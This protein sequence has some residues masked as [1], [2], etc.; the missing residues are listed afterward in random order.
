MRRKLQLIALAALASMVAVAAALSAP[1]TREASPRSTL[2]RPDDAR[3]PQIHVV[4][5]VPSD[6]ADHGLDTDGTLEATVHSWNE[7][8][9]SQTGG[10]GG[11]RLD[12]S[13]GGLD[14]TFFRDPHSDAEIE[15]Q[16]PFVRDLLERDL[17][18]AG[19]NAPEKVYAV[20]YDGTSSWSCGGGAWP[21]ELPGNVAAMYLHGIPSSPTPCDRNAF[22]PGGAPGYL[23]FGMLHEIMHTLGFVA[24]CA[25]RQVRAGHVPEPV[26]DLMY[27]GDAPWQLPAVLDSGHDDYFQTGRTDC[28]DFARS[29][30]LELNAPAVAAPVA[31]PKPKPKPPKC[32]RGQHSTKRKPCR[33][34]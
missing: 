27:G 28:P 24:A 8:L 12:T 30:Y 3:G 21:P 31:K 23:E 20:Y 29:P 4:Y 10:E 22:V 17:H 32:K 9:A 14:V 15:A 1:T 2:D 26:N 34:H 25:S 33:R 13:R 18:K 11:L 16:G 19:L 6:G 5:A 7:W